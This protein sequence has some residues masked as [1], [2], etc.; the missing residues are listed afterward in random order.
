MSSSQALSTC[1]SSDMSAKYVEGQWLSLLPWQKT[2]LGYYL[3]AFDMLLRPHVTLVELAGRAS[4]ISLSR[5]AHLCDGRILQLYAGLTTQGSCQHT[6]R[7][8]RPFV[9]ITAIKETAKFTANRPIIQSDML[10]KLNT[11]LKPG[12]RT[13]GPST[14]DSS[15]S[16]SGVVGRVKELHP[17]LSIFHGD[18]SEVPFPTPSPPVSPSKHGRGGMFKRMSRTPH[19]EPD[20]FSKVG[21]PKKV[22]SL[23]TLAAGE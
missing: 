18:D 23:A 9:L 16:R 5:F 4:A 20:T 2:S 11:F 10:S 22:K 6:T 21:L 1:G 19:D 7:D 13:P 15:S 12:S 17:N 8:N 14:D 3:G